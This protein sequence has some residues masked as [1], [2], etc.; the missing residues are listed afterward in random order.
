VLVTHSDLYSDVADKVYRLTNTDGT[1][2]VTT[3]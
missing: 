1:T 3:E 2:H